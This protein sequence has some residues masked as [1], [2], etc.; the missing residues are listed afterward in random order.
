ML[1][2]WALGCYWRKDGVAIWEDPNLI[3]DGENERAASLLASQAVSRSRDRGAVVA[4]LGR[5]ALADLEV[6]EPG[7]NEVVVD[8]RYQGLSTGQ[9][10]LNG[11]QFTLGYHF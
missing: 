3:A 9:N 8:I 2:R 1:P 7:P 10:A 6:D 5:L 4:E 11:W